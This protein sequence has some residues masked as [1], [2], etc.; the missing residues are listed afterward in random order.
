MNP[1]DQLLSTITVPFTIAYLRDKAR[2]AGIKTPGG[3]VKYLED[4]G[5]SK[6]GDRWSLVVRGGKQFNPYGGKS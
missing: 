1:F 4:H 2:S 5:Y 6:S 3:F